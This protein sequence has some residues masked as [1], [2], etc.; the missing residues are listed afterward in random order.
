MTYRSP[1]PTARSYPPIA[2]DSEH[3]MPRPA[4]LDYMTHSSTAAP[5][6]NDRVGGY[7][8][9]RKIGEGPNAGVFV[10]YAD[11]QNRAAVKVYRLTAQPGCAEREMEALW[12][13]EHDHV[14]RLIDVAHRALILERLEWG[15]LSELLVTRA[16]LQLGEVV[17]VLSPIAATVDLMHA[18]GVA[19]GSISTHSILFRAGGAPV[20]A[21]F[22]S[23]SLFE[24]GLTVD[25]LGRTEAVQ[26]DRVALLD[27]AVSLLTATGETRVESLI[28]WCL[29]QRPIAVDPIGLELAERLFRLDHPV[30]VS[31]AAHESTVE[32]QGASARKLPSN[33]RRRQL[34][35]LNDRAESASRVE[36]LR[37]LWQTVRTEL[38]NRVSTV[39][40]PIWLAFILSATALLGALFA[41]SSLDSQASAAANRDSQQRTSAAS[42]QPLATSA[43]ATAAAVSDD[44][45]PAAQSLLASRIRCF[46]D[47]SLECLGEVTQPGSSARTID[48]A[49][50]VALRSGGETEVA[51]LHPG[52]IELIEEVGNSAIIAVGDES[53]P[54]S[55]LLV[56]GEAGWLIRSIFAN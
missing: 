55:V 50:I 10:G 21:C 53:N 17:N 45:I 7:R 36:K 15:S 16:P 34:P 38:T 35:A 56:K 31:F 13:A 29:Q 3:R 47:H 33:S 23:S 32:D 12:R 5:Q 49:A 46:T 26:R 51:L 19:H 1:P 41:T 25:A 48:S 44:P 28:S 4:T 54:A 9:L 37:G 52:R 20:L 43:S 42:P 2:I 39:R 40:K 18:R 8:L 27:L 24:S 14:V 30:P 11:D 6:L 22:G